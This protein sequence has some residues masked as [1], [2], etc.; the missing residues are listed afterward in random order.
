MCQLCLINF[1]F[2]NIYSCT[3]DI[4]LCA[5]IYK[6]IGVCTDQSVLDKKTYESQIWSLCIAEW[7][8]VVTSL[9]RRDIM[10]SDTSGLYD[11][12]FNFFSLVLWKKTSDPLTAIK[13]N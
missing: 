7:H 9:C 2:F 3:Q 12:P 13:R 1:Y 6:L 8:N 10:T 5:N 4:M 11:Y